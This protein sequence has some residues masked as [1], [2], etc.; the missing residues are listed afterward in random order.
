M[1]TELSVHADDSWGL[2]GSAGSLARKD[3]AASMRS[4]RMAESGLQDEYG[5][6]V[7]P[8]VADPGACCPTAVRECT[9]PLRLSRHQ[10]ATALL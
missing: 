6:E 8:N 9:R 2:G 7:S 3:S 10:P 1:P 5:H 4:S